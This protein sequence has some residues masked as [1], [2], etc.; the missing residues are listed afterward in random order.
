MM[1]PSRHLV[2]LVFAA[3]FPMAG[4]AAMAQP[5]IEVKGQIKAF[6]IAV[7]APRLLPDAA[8]ASLEGIRSEFHKTLEFDLS[9]SGFFELKDVSAYPGGAAAEGLTD[10]TI[11]FDKW[12]TIG[13]KA[14]I[15][16]GLGMMG[17][18]PRFEVHLFDTVAARELWSNTYK[19]GLNEVRQKAHQAA[20]DIVQYFTNE[21]GAFDTRIAF[22]KKLPGKTEIWTMDYD[23]AN[24]QPAVRNGHRSL[25]PS[26]HPSGK[27]MLFTSWVQGKPD[28]FEYDLEKNISRIIS[29]RPEMNLGGFYSPDGKSIAFTW[30]QDGN[31][32]VYRL[33][34][35][36]SSPVRLTNDW[37]IDITPSWSPD[38]KQIAFVSNRS[39]N[40]H[41]YIMNADGSSPKRL[42]FNGD[43]NQT[44]RWSPRGDVIAFTARDD[45]KIMDL[46]TIHVQTGE[47][48][49]L[50]QDQGNNEEPSWSPNGRYLT[51]LSDRTGTSQVWIMNADGANQRRITNLNQA[52]QTPSWGPWS[53]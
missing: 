51:F 27:R 16:T 50:T 5:K 42:T 35:D 33:N 46:F 21:R 39:G 20:N 14:L 26:W 48:K 45:R 40:P 17:G 9:F 41:I 6:P 31:H 22:V 13:A 10:A 15:K 37:S 36:G 3:A 7:D 25:F 19:G 11:S 28:L 52:L 29:N 32:E 8:G 30:S 4:T 2:V 38:G 12:L 23:G 49:R 18:R 34:P 24:P 47:L 43:Y 53:Q 1:P 44:P